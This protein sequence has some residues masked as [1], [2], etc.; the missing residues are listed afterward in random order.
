ML[1][2]AMRREAAEIRGAVAVKPAPRVGRASPRIW[3][4]PV[5]RGA[6]S[7]VADIRRP[8]SCALL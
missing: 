5:I 3:D 6:L 2:H 8:P 1:Q 4:E 7:D